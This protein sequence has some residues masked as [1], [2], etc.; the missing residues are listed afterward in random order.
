MKVLI[1]IF[2]FTKAGGFRVLTQL[3]N[4]GKSFGYEVVIV[5]PLTK[6]KPYYPIDVEVYF[7]NNNGDK[8]DNSYNIE[9]SI[10]EKMIS[11]YKFIKKNSINFDTIIATHYLTTYPALFGNFMKK[12]YYIQAY[13][14]E[15]YNEKRNT[16]KKYL[17]KTLAWST[18]F[19][20][21][22]KIVNSD[23]YK[24]YKNISTEN[25][26]E[27]GLDLNIFSQK[28]LEKTQKDFTVVGC[29]GRK[30]EWKGAN[31]VGKAIEILHNN[32]VNIKF[33]VAFNAVDYPSHELVFPDGDSNLADFYRSLDILVAPGHIQLG[34]V[35]YPVIEAM[36]CGTSVITTGYV[37]A[38]NENSYIVPIKSPDKIA[39]AILEI[40]NNREVALMKLEQ[41]KKDI[42]RFSW[43]NV[44]NKFYSIIGSKI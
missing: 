16:P 32:G 9:L 34:A 44:S 40:I 15:F 10:T 4:R 35:H 31:D 27:P 11:I 24:K 17:L 12:I 25:V 20:P 36:A 23:L 18:Y 28:K 6:T 1:P 38:N 3:A 37:P 2:N 43:E 8:T 39:H 7:I 22:E 42:E 19:F 41:A 5:C 30:E 26:V 33:K 14:P 13:E 29:I 21:F